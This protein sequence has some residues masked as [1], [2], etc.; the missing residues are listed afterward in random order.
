MPRL[1]DL[2]VLFFLSPVLSTRSVTYNLTIF[3]HCLPYCSCLFCNGRGRRV[4]VAYPWV[5]SV[6]QGVG[7]CP[8][9]PAVLLMA[10]TAICKVAIAVA[11]LEFLANLECLRTLYSYLADG[12]PKRR[13]RRWVLVLLAVAAVSEESS[14][15][16][17]AGV[18]LLPCNG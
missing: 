5:G 16:S 8:S 6:N 4:Q 9:G 7:T 18:F 11:L 15:Y 13:C 17:L 3:G 1:T 10:F 2:F 14:I 12:W